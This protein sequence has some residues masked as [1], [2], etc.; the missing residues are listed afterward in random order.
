MLNEEQKKQVQYGCFLIIP[1]K[2]DP[3]AFDLVKLEKIGVYQSLTTMDLNEN[4]KAMLER[5]VYK[6]QTLPCRF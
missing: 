3:A 6:R 2:Y 4:I 5:D 1:L